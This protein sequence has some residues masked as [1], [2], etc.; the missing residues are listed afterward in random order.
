MY[1]SAICPFCIAAER[2]LKIKGVTEIEKIMIDADPEQRAQML[3][4]TERRTVPQIFIGERHIG[5]YEDIVAL[6]RKGELMNLL[7]PA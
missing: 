2:F 6:D 7:I 5:G 4:L 3:H 1:S